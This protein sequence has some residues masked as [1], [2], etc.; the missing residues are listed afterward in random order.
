MSGRIDYRFFILTGRIKA[1]GR[2]GEL[3]K[4]SKKIELRL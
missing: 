1:F 3:V 4:I 2:N